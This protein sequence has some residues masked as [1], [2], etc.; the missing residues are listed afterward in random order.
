MLE[1]EPPVPREMT[2]NRACEKVIKLGA[3][4]WLSE[5]SV[6]LLISAQVMISQFSRWSPVTGFVLT[7]QS[8]LGILALLSLCSSPAHAA[9]SLS[10]NK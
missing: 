8:L 4:G 6:R 3:A 1:P 2:R 9:L 5:L 10:Q 7:V